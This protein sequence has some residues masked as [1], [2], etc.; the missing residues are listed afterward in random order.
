MKTYRTGFLLALIGNIVL[1]GVLVGLWLHYRS[2]KPMTDARTKQRMPPSTEFD[3]TRCPTAG[4]DRSGT[5]SGANSAAAVAKHRSEDRPGRT[6]S[7][8]R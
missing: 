1:A 5:G 8:R 7:S 2:A 3:D 4:I 6:K